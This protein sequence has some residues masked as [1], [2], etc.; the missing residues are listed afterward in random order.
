MSTQITVRLPDDM[1][2]MV[3]SLVTSGRARSRASVVEQA[4]EHEVRRLLTERDVAI[5]RGDGAP[6]DL[7]PLAAWAQGRPVEGLDG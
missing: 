3:D 7:A 5:L 6:D 2:A 1:V 4:L